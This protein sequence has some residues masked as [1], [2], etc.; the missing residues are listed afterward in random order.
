MA[1]QY[2]NRRYYEQLRNRDNGL[3]E[4]S[5]RG[6]DLFR[7]KLRLFPRREVAAFVHSVIVDGFVVG[8]LRPALRRSVDLS[9]ENS[10]HSG[11]RDIDR[12]EVADVVLPVK[13]HARGPSIRQPVERDVVE[14]LIEG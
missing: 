3:S 4:R 8:P 1:D 9:R 12:V 6:T 7:E 10:H 11:N 13:P 2:S 14:H 5:K